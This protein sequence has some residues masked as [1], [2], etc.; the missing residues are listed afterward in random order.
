MATLPLPA[1]S[2]PALR[3]IRRRSLLFGLALL[4]LALA[5]A[6]LPLVWNVLAWINGLSK[7]EGLHQALMQMPLASWL[8]MFVWGAAVPLTLI[9]L[10]LRPSRALALGLAAAMLGAVAWYV[11]MPD[12]G[13]CSALYAQ[14]SWCGSLRWAQTLSLAIATSVYVFAI[15]LA[16]L[17]GL[18]MLLWPGADAPRADSPRPPA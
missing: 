2:P 10:L 9:A 16:A 3:S 8:L 6:I 18:G 7:W 5:G 15:F 11:H 12:V 14:A 17:A 1:S 13:Q 4:S